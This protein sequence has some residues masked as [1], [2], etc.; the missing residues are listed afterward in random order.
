MV[1]RFRTFC[2]AVELD[3]RYS[4]RGPLLVR[5][6]GAS[7]PEHPDMAFVRYPG[8]TGPVP[9]LPGSSLKGVLRTGAEQILRAA[10]ERVCDPFERSAQ[11]REPDDRCA[12]CLLFGSTLGAGVLVVDDAL[13]WPQGSGTDTQQERIR[14]LEERSVVRHGV[15]IDRR[16]GAA[17]QGVLY[18]FEALVD[19]EFFGSLRLRNPEPSQVALISTALLLLREGLLR[20]GAM[21][22]RGLGWVKPYARRIVVHAVDP[23]SA[24]PILATSSAF[25]AEPSKQGLLCS[26]QAGGADAAGPDRM[27]AAQRVLD[28]WARSIGTAGSAGDR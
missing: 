13:P 9:F 22:T 8:L 28:D 6:G 18:D 1:D 14:K 20:V 24:Q 12:V 16:T 2:T 7:P 27:R 3:L 17:R 15:G 25:P 26:W 23:A 10:G 11:C 5:A 19:A 4:G 21:T